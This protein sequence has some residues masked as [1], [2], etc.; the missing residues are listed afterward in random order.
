MHQL[1]RKL[2]GGDRRSIG[3]VESVIHAV[4]KKPALFDVLFG[5]LSVDDPLVRMRAA[6]AVEKISADQPDLLQPFKKTIIRLAGESRQQEVRWHLAQIIPRLKL[7]PRERAQVVD[8]LFDYLS[9]NSKIVVTFS[10]Q[11]LTDFATEDKK[12]RPRVVGILKELTANGSPAIKNRG[13]K[14]LKK[15]PVPY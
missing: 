15:L 6:D 3:N 7:T 13:Q 2:T 12:L 10:L 9:D 14:L 1:L 8:I 4:G 11:A 5:G